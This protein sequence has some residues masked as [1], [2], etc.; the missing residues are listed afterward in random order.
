MA[1]G[2]VELVH[3]CNLKHMRMG[4]AKMKS[5]KA[6]EGRIEYG[7][8]KSGHKRKYYVPTDKTIVWAYRL[9]AVM[10]YL[11]NLYL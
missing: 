9:E 3:E 4:T 6:E 10:N 5:D 8:K 1:I 2:N 7:K 11:T